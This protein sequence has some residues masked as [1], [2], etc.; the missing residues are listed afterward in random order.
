[1]GRKGRNRG[2][3]SVRPL[4]IAFLLLPSRSDGATSTETLDASLHGAAR[5]IANLESVVESKSTELRLVQQAHAEVQQLLSLSSDHSTVLA[6]EVKEQKALHEM[7]EKELRETKRVARQVVAR[8]Q[9]ELRELQVELDRVREAYARLE[10]Q[11]ASLRTAAEQTEAA[12]K[13]A[14]EGRRIVEVDAK[15][16][17]KEAEEVIRRLRDKARLYEETMEREERLKKEVRLFSFT[18]SAV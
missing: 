2:R 13:V 11:L 4:C 12:W 16:E 3:K 8:E 6:V 10:K 18:P 7:R 15:R 17:K 14:R 1:L 9:E 5:E